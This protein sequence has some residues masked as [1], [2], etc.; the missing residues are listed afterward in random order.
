MDW[1]TAL[2]KSW[3]FIWH[4]DSIWS[5]IA[6]VVIAFVLI[7]FIVY[8]LL[9]LLLGTGLPVVAVVS[10]SME[11]K[12]VP[13]CNQ[14]SP[15]TGLCTGHEQGVYEICGKQ[16]SD[17]DRLETAE[18]WDICGGWYQANSDITLTMFEQFPF[19]NGFNTGDIMVLSGPA[20]LQQ[21]DVIVYQLAGRSYPIIHR[22]V[23]SNQTSAGAIYLI[24]GDHNPSPDPFYVHSDQ[25]LGKAI[26]RIPYLGYI[27]I[28]AVKALNFARGA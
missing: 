1:K 27:K 16:F 20:D 14:L 26:F 22:I 19:P 2:K 9:G 25:M 13:D 28:W 17:A 6:N 10:G 12:I 15:Y 11:H 4:D 21:G 24:K 18:Y 8:P 3:H 23:S 7:K 5:W